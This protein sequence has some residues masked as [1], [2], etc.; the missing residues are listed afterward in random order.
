[1]LWFKACARC[2]GD[3]TE[4][5]DRFGNFVVCM[6]CGNYLTDRQEMDLR[7]MP[8]RQPVRAGRAA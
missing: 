5:S 2:K 7:A 8:Q 6:Q 1:M 3:L 4:G